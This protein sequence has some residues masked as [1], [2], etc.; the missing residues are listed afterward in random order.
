MRS[1]LCSLLGG[2]A[3]P[4]LALGAGGIFSLPP[5]SHLDRARRLLVAVVWT[6]GGGGW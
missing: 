1:G 3:A 4:P 2:G 6:S 5:W